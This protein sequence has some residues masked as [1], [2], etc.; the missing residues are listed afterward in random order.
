MLGPVVSLV[1]GSRVP[2]NSELILHF[3]ASE[4]MESHVH[5][6]GTSRLNVVVHNTKRC[7][8]VGLHWAGWLL[9][10]HLFECLLLGNSL[11]CIDV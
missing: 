10:V 11:S 8:V 4:P 1:G 6:F 7:C 3:L 2:E 5:G 9:M